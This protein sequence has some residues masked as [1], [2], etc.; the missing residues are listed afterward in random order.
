MRFAKSALITF[1]ARGLALLIGVATSIITA[2]ALGPE[3][4]GVLALLLF[5]QGLT[6]TFGMMGM[7][8]SI[9]YFIAR[10][11]E[12]ASAVVQ[13]AF[14]LA[15]A[16]GVIVAGLLWIA[17]AAAPTVVLGGIDIRY[18]EIF[19]LSV[20]FTFLVNYLQTV[21]IARQ[22]FV[23]FNVLDIAVRFLQMSAF[24]V[25]LIGLGGGT[26]AAVRVVTGVAAVAGVLYLV[27]VNRL[28]PFR[29][30][31]DVGL[32]KEMFSYGG[33]VWASSV[34]MYVAVRVHLLLINTMLG[35]S[36][37][38][39]YSVA[40]QM[41]DVVSIIPLTFGVILF[42]KVSAGEDPSGTL[43]MRVLRSTVVI[44]IVFCGLIAAH[45]E[46]IVLVLFGPDFHEAAIVLQIL[47]PGVVA[48][49]V[50]SI[51]NNHLAGRGLP[52]VVV[53]AP[54]AALLA[55][56]PA[57]WLTL[58]RFGLAASAVVASTGYLLIAV[59]L[60]VYVRRQLNAT[61]SSLIVLH[62]TDLRF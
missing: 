30:G 42:P 24:A 28:Q 6:V 44:M 35:E 46:Q 16:G 14:S 53:L 32:F 3:G 41:V 62:R 10:D 25:V 54:L 27:R 38:G 1:L 45:S 57:L 59:I 22:R 8:G 5:F 48:L 19:L 39:V 43:M 11:P 9:T 13:N 4:R 26:F 33:R 47:M 18:L 61:W 37:A 60:I 36:P 2:R 55:M 15:V 58:P 50:A 17:A 31:F 7:N 29:P 21:F 20:P 49:S 34:L 12:R 56:V 40:M 52:M 23:E 51:L